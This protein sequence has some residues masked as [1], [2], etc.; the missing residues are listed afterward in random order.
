MWRRAGKSQDLVI[1]H[2]TNTHHS[3]GSAWHR[4]AVG[5]G[6]AG[7]GTPSVAAALFAAIAR[8]GRRV[9][10]LRQSA[11]PEERRCWSLCRCCAVTGVRVEPE[12]P[13]AASQTI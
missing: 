11:E 7:D 6:A 5:E 4:L 10:F 8:I 13:A 1:R 9:A 2:H 3:S 12:L